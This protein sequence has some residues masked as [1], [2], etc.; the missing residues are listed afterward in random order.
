MAGRFS[1]NSL[2]HIWNK[3][4]ITCT[5]KSLILNKF[6][7]N[8]LYLWSKSQSQHH[9]EKEHWPHRC[10]RHL[11]KC[12]WINFKRQTWTCQHKHWSMIRFRFKM[13]VCSLMMIRRV[14]KLV[15][16][17]ENAKGVLVSFENN[18]LF[19]QVSIKLRHLQKFRQKLDKDMHYKY[20]NPYN[21]RKYLFI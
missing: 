9:Q 3:N 6:G 2:S 4:Q 21:N 16:I 17:A 14:E 13:L 5:Y 15:N 12:F 7:K 19:C 11:C 8:Y 10:N 20:Y 18:W 1:Y